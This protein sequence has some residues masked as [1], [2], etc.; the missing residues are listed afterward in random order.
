MSSTS[1]DLLE[2]PEYIVQR[3][4][5]GVWRRCPFCGERVW[6]GPK[7]KR[8]PGFTFHL[9]IKNLVHSTNSEWKV[10]FEKDSWHLGH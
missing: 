1:T 4:E 5:D 8:A 7:S 2:Y 9:S 6:D 3:N 10:K